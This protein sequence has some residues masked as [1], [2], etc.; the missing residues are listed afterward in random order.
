MSPAPQ[1][2]ALLARMENV[3]HET[4]AHLALIER[5]IEA[6]AERMTITSRT[7]RRHMGRGTSTWTRVDECMFHEAMTVLMRVSVIPGQ[8]FR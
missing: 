3:L 1:H 6:R 2:R 5:Q 8:G 4:R 7:K